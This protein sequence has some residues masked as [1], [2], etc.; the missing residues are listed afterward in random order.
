MPSP[1]HRTL[2]WIAALTGALA[3]AAGA[4]GS[5]IIGDADPKA[6]HRFAIAVK[7][8]QLHALAFLAL[9]AA[10]MAGLQRWLPTAILWLAG[11]ILFCGSLYALAL[12]ADPSFA[13]VAPSGGMAMIAG[14]LA[15]VLT[16]RPSPQSS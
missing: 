8:H 10:A 16:K 13:K 15:L 4:I 6:A 12:G 9:A 3:V 11:M 14:W 2:V 5:H 1:S 7:Y